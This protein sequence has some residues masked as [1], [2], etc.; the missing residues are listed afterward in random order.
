MASYVLLRLQRRYLCAQLSSLAN[1]ICYTFSSASLLTILRS[2]SR[3][4]AWPARRDRQ[5]LE[6]ENRHSRAKLN[7]VRDYQYTD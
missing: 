4:G 2:A 7:L 6:H 5:D 1:A 3:R